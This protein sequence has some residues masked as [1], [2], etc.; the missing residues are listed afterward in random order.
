MRSP[1]NLA[2][3]CAALAGIGPNAGAILVAAL[4][5][6]AASDREVIPREIEALRFIGASLGVDELTVAHIIEASVRANIASIDGAR[7]EVPPTAPPEHR[8]A[9]RGAAPAST[10]ESVPEL[11]RAYR[12]LGVRPDSDVAAV[13]AAYLGLVERYNPA[14][15]AGLGAEFAV[16]AV[17]RL[18]D[19]TAAFERIRGA[20]HA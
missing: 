14:K 12:I 7:R 6:I 4:A 19:A 16:L 11:D 2:G 17:R 10:R 20:S 5:E 8:M 13:N 18:A 15:L 1:V 3:T 9:S